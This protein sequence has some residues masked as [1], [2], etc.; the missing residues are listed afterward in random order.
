M[1][2]VYRNSLAAVS[3]GLLLW[4]QGGPLA[5]AS[6][7]DDKAS[8]E[9]QAEE[10]RQQSDQLAIEIES[11]SEQ[12]R[13][14]DEQADAA[15]AEHRARKAEL[16]DTLARIREN[17]ARLLE[18]RADYD[19]KSEQ[20]GKRVRDIYINGQISY[21]DVL[22]GAKDFSDL[23]TRM[24]LLKRVIKQDFDLVQKVIEEKS[25]IERTQLS[26]EKDREK[27]DEQEKR[28]RLT[29]Q[30]MEDKVAKRQLIIDRLK[31][32]KA[33]I[34]AQYDEFM[35][36]SKHIEEMLR[37]SSYASATPA[38][39]SG[40]SGAMIWP[41]AGPITSEFGWRVHPISGTQ[42]FHS[43]LDIGGDYGMP[44]AAAQSGTVEYAGW[45][46]GYGNTVIL[47]HGGG[48]TTLYGHNESLAVG[49]G[50]TVSQ[51]ETI[52]YCGS[53]GNSTGPHCHFE[54]RQGG[55]PVSPYSYL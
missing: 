35:A 25:E 31:N 11:I 4:G 30:D 34:D 16:D 55:E 9:Q 41:I 53:T 24:D 5:H 47:N 26:L 8:Y 51:G 36:A 39:V 28:A 3:L 32:D 42:K 6:L 46:S 33:T 21:L 14:L 18:V 37:Q 48:I 20:L 17:G 54:V 40:G 44:I 10:K 23:M 38:M 49:V 29:R 19:R 45:I 1:K 22:F 2:A 43:G 7:E 52:A 50:Q 13:L 12:K 15:I 27:Q